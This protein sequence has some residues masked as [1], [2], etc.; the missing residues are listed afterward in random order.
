MSISRKDNKLRVA[1][2]LPVAATAVKINSFQPS[3]PPLEPDGFSDNQYPPRA[4]SAR[5]VT[6]SEAGIKNEHKNKTKCVKM[7]MICERNFI[8]VL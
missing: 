6:G 5:L 8:S 1:W 7:Q 3:A 4:V 2:L